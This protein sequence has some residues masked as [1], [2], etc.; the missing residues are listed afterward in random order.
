M[1]TYVHLESGVFEDSSKEAPE[2]LYRMIKSP[3]IAPEMPDIL[4][5]NFKCGFP[6]KVSNEKAGIVK[7]KLLEMFQYLNDI[8]HGV[9]CF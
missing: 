8:G 6:V 1:L 4:W 5:I 3:T 7:D 9:I 2:E